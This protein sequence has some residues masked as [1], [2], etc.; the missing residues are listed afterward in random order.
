LPSLGNYGVGMVFFPTDE[1]LIKEC[2]EVIERKS[3]KLG[4]R[5]L[6]YRLVPVDNSEISRNGDYFPSRFDAQADSIML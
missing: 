4:L 3:K 5:V 6:G 1:N 2:K